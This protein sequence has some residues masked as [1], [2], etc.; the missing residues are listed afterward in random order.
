MLCCN[1][2]LILYNASLSVVEHAEQGGSGKTS[3]TPVRKCSRPWLPWK[4][5]EV[6]DDAK[7]AHRDSTFRA[8][9]AAHRMLNLCLKAEDP[10]SSR[11]LHQ[12]GI[13]PQFEV[14]VFSVSVITLR[15][16]VEY[17]L[18]NLH[19]VLGALVH[20]S[21]MMRHA[22]QYSILF[23]TGL[24]SGQ[25]INLLTDQPGKSKRMN[26][27]LLVLHQYRLREVMS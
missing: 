25:I 7:G 6:K 16:A 27:L 17:H 3:D 26:V 5:R 22:D 13:F 23:S 21:E 8:V 1:P 18:L 24:R 11:W 14:E 2:D 10:E 15:W 12:Q 19:C 4:R 20:F 9:C